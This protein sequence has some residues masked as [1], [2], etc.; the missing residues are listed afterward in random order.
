MNT[1]VLPDLYIYNSSLSDICLS[2]FSSLLAIG[3]DRQ[4]DV[5]IAWAAVSRQLCNPEI[6]ACALIHCD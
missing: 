6:W 4:S 3:N 1:T 5:L 2:A